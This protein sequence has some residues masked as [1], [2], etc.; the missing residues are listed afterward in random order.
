MT[1]HRSLSK[2]DD[3]QYHVL[4]LYTMDDTDEFGSKEG[5]D[6]K[7]KSGAVEVLTK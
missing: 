5:Q 6:E 4:P 1:K 2:P 7:V 3:E